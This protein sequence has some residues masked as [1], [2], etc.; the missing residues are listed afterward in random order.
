[1]SCSSSLC[2][3]NDSLPFIY[4]DIVESVYTL[5]DLI[6]DQVDPICKIDLCLPSVNIYDLNDSRL[7]C[8]TC[9]DQI[10][11]E[12]SPLLEHFC[13]AINEPQTSDEIDKVGHSNWSDSLGIMFVEDP[14]T[15]LTPIDHV[16]ENSLRDDIFL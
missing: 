1:M 3:L 9:V 2:D 12:V 14:T 10:S 13:N 4:N 11:C 6:D 5:V 8:D 15:C 7:S 16:N